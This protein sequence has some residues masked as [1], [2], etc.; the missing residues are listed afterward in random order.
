MQGKKIN[1][2]WQTPLNTTCL[3]LRYKLNKRKHFKYFKGNRFSRR[4]VN[5]LSKI[6]P[7]E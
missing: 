3:H 7:L 6:T 4:L 5:S 1:A 2:M